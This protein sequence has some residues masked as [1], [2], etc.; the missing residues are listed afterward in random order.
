MDEH[1]E[2]IRAILGAVSA[3][4]PSA[5]S[6]KRS[7]FDAPPPSNGPRAADPTARAA[8]AAPVTVA[9]QSKRAKIAVSLGLASLAAATAPASASA[10]GAAASAAPALRAPRHTVSA[11]TFDVDSMD[12][13]QLVL[14]FLRESGFHAAMTSLQHEADVGLR[15]VESSAA[16]AADIKAGRWDAVLPAVSALQLSREK[17]LFLYEQATLEMVE[18]GEHELARMLLRQSAPFAWLKADNP[19]RCVAARS[20]SLL[21]LPLPLILSLA[22]PQLP[23]LRAARDARRVARVA[24]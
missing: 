14:Q 19:E 16:L 20:S 4:R 3:P 22:S 7:R 5:T 24:L 15:A 6:K 23:R 2:A 9:V 13:V 18:S 11:G 17:Q 12:V 1:S 21:L 10:S 8:A